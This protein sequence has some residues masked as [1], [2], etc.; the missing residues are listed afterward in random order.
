MLLWYSDFQ[1]VSVSKA[2]PKPALSPTL[3][4]PNITFML[5]VESQIVYVRSLTC[6]IP[7]GSLLGPIL[8][9]LY[10]IPVADNIK[11]HIWGVKYHF[12]ADVILSFMLLSSVIPWRMRTW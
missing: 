9:V 4:H 7:Q 5:R 10:M 11:A 6:G 3:S 12:Y 1:I 2:R 8:Y